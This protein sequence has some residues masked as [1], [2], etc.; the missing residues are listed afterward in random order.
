MLMLMLMLMFIPFVLERLLSNGGVKMGQKSSWEVSKEG[1]LSVAMPE[2]A[3]A[4]FDLTDIWPDY[5]S[6]SEVQQYLESYGVKQAL[7]DK[8]A[9]NK[10][11]SLSEAEKVGVILHTW[12]D[13]KAGRIR[14]R[15]GGVSLKKQNE[16]LQNQL[17]E[18]KEKVDQVL[19]AEQR[20]M[21][22]EMGIKF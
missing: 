2:G 18:V 12:E 10:E 9:R 7:S 13:F 17:D 1:M 21:L 11:V 3:K 15:T 5:T 4:E 16:A 8:T 22:E 14:A 19:T 6:H 20:K